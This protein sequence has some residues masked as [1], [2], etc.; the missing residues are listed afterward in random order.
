MDA[1]GLAYAL[2]A[3]VAIALAGFAGYLLWSADPAQAHGGSDGYEVY[4]PMGYDEGHEDE[5]ERRGG[6]M[7]PMMGGHEESWAIRG[8]M[9]GEHGY[10]MDED[11]CYCE[12]EEMM[13]EFMEEMPWF[14][15]DEWPMGWRVFDLETVT[16]VVVEVDVK[17]LEIVVETADGE[18]I[19]AKA[20]MR[21]VNM[22]D[23]AITF[24]PWIL[25]QLEPGDEVELTVAE[26]RFASVALG[27]AFGGEE[28]LHP[29]LAFEVLGEG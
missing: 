26:A 20:L 10:P 18:T 17:R 4:R 13:E 6:P 16:G 23:G 11:M 7:A 25:A 28:Y 5:Y 9:G 19:E 12:M 21:Y 3:S 2:V 24:G 1:R 14:D 27:I 22:S 8:G 15:W 29:L